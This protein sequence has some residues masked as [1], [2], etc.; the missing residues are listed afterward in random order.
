[1]RRQDFDQAVATGEANLDAAELTRRHCGHARI[2]LA[3]GNS[4]VGD[5]LGLPMGLL[6]VR[7]E[8]APPPP[9]Q[10]HAALD[11][12]VEFYQANCV[13][14]PHH[15]P[16]GGWPT[17]ATVAGQRAAEQA[18]RQDAA[19]RA[20]DAR[21][22]R[23]QQRRERRRQVM[24]GEGHVVRDLA[25]A[26]DRIDR[27]EPRTGPP[28]DQEARGARQVT[29]AARAAPEL[30]SPVLVGSLLELA[31]DAAD[32][33]A[34]EAL[35]ALVRAGRCPPRRALAAAAAVLRQHRSAP[36]AHLLAVLEPDLRPGDLLGLLDQLI[37]LAS[38][39]EDDRFWPAPAP[40]G[41]I[42]A[43]HVDLNAVT[44]RI[45][46]HLASDD[47]LIRQA[48]ADAAGVLLAADAARVIALGPPLAASI[49]GED[50]GYAGEPHPAAAA[51][52]ALAEA[53]RGQPAL[54][55]Q[56]I[57]TRA[58]GATPEARAELSRVPWFLQRFREQWDAPADAT[59]E[60]VS[61]V[62]RR[63]GG[64]WG[65]EAADHAAEHLESLAGEIPGAVA[66]HVGEMLGTILALCAQGR[67]EQPAVA[68]PAAGMPAM[69]AALERDTL[70]SRRDA[71]RRRLAATIGRCAEA[72]PADVLT[73]VH[74]LFSATTGQAD[75][76][77]AVRTT[78]LTALQEAVS[79]ETLRDMLPVT[80][81]ALLDG[82]QSVRRGGIGLWAACAAVAGSLPAELAELSVPLL[83]DSYVIVHT[84]MLEQIPRLGLPASLAPR[85]LPLAD[86]WAAAYAA[87]PGTGT[88]ESAVRAI[89]SLARDLEDRAQATAWLSVALSYAGK[90]PPRARR[91][92]LL[93]WWPD[94]LR[95]SQAWTSAALASAASPELADYYNQRH[96]PVLQALMDRPQVLAGTPLAEIEPLS[97]IHRPPYT[98]RA[99]EPAELLQSADRWAD[100][101]E[102]ARSVEARQ[103]PGEER[104]PRFARVP[105]V[106]AGVDDRPAV[107]VVPDG[108]V[109]VQRG[110]REPGITTGDH[111]RE[112]DGAD[113]GV[114][115]EHAGRFEAPDLLRPRLGILVG[116]AHGRHE[117]EGAAGAGPGGRDRG[118]ERATGIGSQHSRSL[119]D[120]QGAVDDHTKGRPAAVDPRGQLRVIG[121][122]G[123]DADEDR[124]VDVAQAVRGLAHR[125]GRDPP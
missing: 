112:R 53:W 29:D 7:C 93:A 65:D 115:D 64:D 35:E 43:S 34:L 41:L 2:E 105:V 97:A 32:P 116:A 91:D 80:Y 62:V 118:H 37:A 119:R 50:A 63:A 101:A 56:I 109:R 89:R 33:A 23:Y 4:R 15:A 110:E 45:A 28:G 49:R 40:E 66:R 20:A 125:R 107:A 22:R 74:H 123:V 79:P 86:R 100:A 85:L 88:L 55:R 24:A 98:W 54:T 6:Q 84:A 108:G 1:M 10:G 61:F 31:R 68:I 17:L 106:D 72:A 3:G 12:A 11:L 117:Y 14:C 69:I 82:D 90:C 75:L 36:A 30:F 26:L 114:L 95:T 57:E 52:R 9:R 67:D 81:T 59:A 78:M 70:R 44:G 121:H 113:V 16:G 102:V 124:V 103:R 5:M 47:E 8:H 120:A 25:A 27:A 83:D 18:A 104:L 87:D 39:E 99:L 111:P 46:D 13:G 71:R 42:T 60:A 21:A 92:L 51:L 122:N 96:D 48:G 77:R 58:A 76:D 38:G 94:E 19:Q 73:P